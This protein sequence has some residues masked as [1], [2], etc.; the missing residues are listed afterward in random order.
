[1]YPIHHVLNGVDTR[2]IKSDS[3][4]IAAFLLDCDPHVKLQKC[5][6][7]SL[8]DFA[9][10][11]VSSN[12]DA[13][14]HLQIVEVIYDA[15]PEAI[16]SQV[17]MQR[18]KQRVQSF[19]RSQLVYVSQARDHRLMTTPDDNAQLPLHKALRGNVRLGSIKLFVKGNPLAYILLII[20]VH[21]HCTSHVRITILLALLGIWWDLIPRLSMPW[22]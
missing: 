11:D 8:L 15:Y 7:Q 5:R 21:Y 10:R 18:C 17:Q 9:C 2:R 13:A 4:D 1:M 12:V 19:I 16:E 6:G 14:L 3:V 20:A 22:I